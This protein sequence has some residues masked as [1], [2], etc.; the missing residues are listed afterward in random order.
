MVISEGAEAGYKVGDYNAEKMIG[1]ASH[2][3]TTTMT[4]E[5]ASTAFAFLQPALKTRKNL[6]VVTDAQVDGSG[7]GDNILMIHVYYICENIYIIIFFYK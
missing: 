2:F 6:R 1:M 5:R 7:G 3:Q 4:G